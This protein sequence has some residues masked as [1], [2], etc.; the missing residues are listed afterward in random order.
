[1][2]SPLSA[3]YVY[4]EADAVLGEKTLRRALPLMRLAMLMPFMVASVFVVLGA[5]VELGSKRSG[6]GLTYFI[7]CPL[8]V[9]VGFY[10]RWR[11]AA[12]SRTTFRKSPH[13]GKTIRWRFDAERAHINTELSESSFA[14]KALLEVKEAQSGFLLFSQPRY[15]HWIPHRAFGSDEALE[16]FRELVRHA[17]VKLAAAS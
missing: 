3:E 9:L 15:A 10:L 1:M 8:F 12:L 6:S 7:V 11:I 14:W 5:I 2:T 16:N 4:V 13:A 17:G